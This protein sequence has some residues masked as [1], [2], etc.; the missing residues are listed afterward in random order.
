M[1]RLI[2]EQ[3][4]P[5]RK[6][7]RTRLHYKAPWRW[8]CLPAALSFLP[9]IIAITSKNTITHGAL[10]FSCTDLS[11]SC[12]K[13]STKP[14]FQILNHGARHNTMALS[15][16]SNLSNWLLWLSG[17]L[18][19]GPSFL[20]Y[21]AFSSFHSNLSLLV[22]RECRTPQASR[23]LLTVIANS[24]KAIK[25]RIQ[26]RKG[27]CSLLH[28]TFT[29]EFNSNFCIMLLAP[30]MVLEQMSVIGLKLFSCFMIP[31]ANEQLLNAELW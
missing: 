29:I 30:R 13:K 9:M 10:V 16:P 14:L 20:T 7:E 26:E 1:S 17:N 5:G 22:V 19:L 12:G 21:L 8:S 28:K 27:R 23:I 24:N 6:P 2:K 25:K 31:S 11:G 4:K 18:A 15:L 3:R